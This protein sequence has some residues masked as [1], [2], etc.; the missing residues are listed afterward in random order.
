MLMQAGMLRSE[1]CDR[2]ADLICVLCY[3]NGCNEWEG[4]V[5]ATRQVTPLNGQEEFACDMHAANCVYDTELS[6]LI[7]KPATISVPDLA[8]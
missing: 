7:E 5:P 4:T 6:R 1:P 8:R 2:D 3:R